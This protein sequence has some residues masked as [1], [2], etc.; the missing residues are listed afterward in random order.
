[1]HGLEEIRA[2]HLAT[3]REFEI[4]L[5]RRSTGPEQQPVIASLV[6]SADPDT[7][8][9]GYWVQDQIRRVV[10]TRRQRARQAAL[11]LGWE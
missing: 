10:T 1:M 9:I 3:T 7:E 5:Q 4:I 2:D 11:D 8:E 6:L